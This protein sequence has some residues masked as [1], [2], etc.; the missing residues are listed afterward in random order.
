[1]ALNCVSPFDELRPNHRNCEH[2]CRGKDARAATTLHP[3]PI[4]PVQNAEGAEEDRLKQCPLYKGSP[5]YSRLVF[6]TSTTLDF[7]PG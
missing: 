4:H 1:M 2:H 6:G 5:P 3:D 7:F